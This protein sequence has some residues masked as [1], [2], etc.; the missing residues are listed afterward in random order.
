MKEVEGGLEG[1]GSFG[2]RELGWENGGAS[3][4]KGAAAGN[5]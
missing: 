3:T 4:T 5:L 2:P 1:R